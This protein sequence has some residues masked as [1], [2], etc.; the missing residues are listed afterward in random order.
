MFGL[1]CR[2]ERVGYEK[3]LFEQHRK[4]VSNSKTCLDTHQYT[5]IKPIPKY[6]M[7]NYLREKQIDRE[8]TYLLER[9]S[10]TKCQIETY[11]HISV[12]RQLQWK[13][14]LSNLKRKQDNYRIN[15]ENQR[16]LSSLQTVKPTICIEKMEQDFKKSRQKIKLMALYP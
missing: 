16:L 12:L 13:K 7:E 1:R 9:L 6:Q 4:R 11:N 5:K 2:N 8:N 14:R 10:R 3:I 15:C